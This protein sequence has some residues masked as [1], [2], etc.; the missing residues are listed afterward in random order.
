MPV[1]MNW[2][3]WSLISDL[4]LKKKMLTLVSAAFH[5]HSDKMLCSGTSAHTAF[6]TR[7]K[8]SV[9]THTWFYGQKMNLY[10]PKKIYTQNINS[11]AHFLNQSVLGRQLCKPHL[12]V[13][14]QN[15]HT[16][17]PNKRDCSSPCH[18]S[19]EPALPQKVTRQEGK[20]G[21]L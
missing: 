12:K 16:P 18:I 8:W 19:G 3:L 4:L 13:W 14:F 5:S 20:R 10:C 15:L 11:N 7:S 6:L 9:L 21:N 1:F 17:S 2:G